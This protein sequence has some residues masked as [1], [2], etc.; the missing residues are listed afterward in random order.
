MEEYEEPKL[1]E[2]SALTEAQPVECANG[3][4]HGGT[5]CI[6]GGNVK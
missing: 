5:W 6:E 3:S 2:I 4:T 1:A